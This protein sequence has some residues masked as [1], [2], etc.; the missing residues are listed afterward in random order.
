[1]LSIWL[2]CIVQNRLFLDGLSKVPFVH[3][4]VQSPLATHLLCAWLSDCKAFDFISKSDPIL[5]A[6]QRALSVVL[7]VLICPGHNTRP[8]L[9]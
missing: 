1:M 9:A 3:V 5:T 8:M 4:Q 6:I 2:Y 7:H